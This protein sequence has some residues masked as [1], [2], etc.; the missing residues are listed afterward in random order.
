MTLKDDEIHRSRLQDSKRPSKAKQEA[1][2]RADLQRRVSRALLRA[3]TANDARAYAEAL[4][5][6]EI[7]ESSPEWKR[8]WDYFY[9][10]R[11]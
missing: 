2:D 6:G 4:R 9:D 10:R 8:A 7:E 5:D 1:A 3:K 11:P